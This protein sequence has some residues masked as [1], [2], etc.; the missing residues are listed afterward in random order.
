MI[1][2]DLVD[3]LES[4]NYGTGGEDIFYNYMIDEPNNVIVV[5][6]LPGQPFIQKMTDVHYNI[7]ITIR[8]TDYD[9]GY[10]LITRMANYFHDR[11]SR[12]TTNPNNGR[13]MRIRVNSAPS[14]L[15]IDNSNRAVFTLYLVVTTIRD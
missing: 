12:Y 9:A 14:L 7:Q 5:T 2:N 6:L 1:L 3:L 15:M 10:E 13:Q 8:N 4:E 11:D